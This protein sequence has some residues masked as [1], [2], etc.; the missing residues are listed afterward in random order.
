MMHIGMALGLATTYPVNIWPVRRGVKHAM[1]RP[2]L[3][4][5]A[6]TAG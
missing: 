4:A 2:A 5:G 1:G 6:R 3:P